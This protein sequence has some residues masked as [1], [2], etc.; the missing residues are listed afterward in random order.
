MG[1]K[2][3]EM[4]QIGHEVANKGHITSVTVLS[5]A[6]FLGSMTT[7]EFLFSLLFILG[8]LILRNAPK[9]QCISTSSNIN[10]NTTLQLWRN[11]TYFRFRNQ[12]FFS[13]LRL[14]ICQPRANTHVG[15]GSG[16]F[17]LPRWGS[18]RFPTPSILSCFITCTSE[19]YRVTWRGIT[20][21]DGLNVLRRLVFSQWKVQ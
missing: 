2:I 11:E 9:L 7:F 12:K 18:S 14:R 5:H 4:V 20:K 16:L 10:Y 3:T 6:V 19:L 17:L 1:R 21:S 15:T 13:T 8:S